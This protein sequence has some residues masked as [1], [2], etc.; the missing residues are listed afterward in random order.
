LVSEPVFD[1]HVGLWKCPYCS[2]MAASRT[3]VARHIQ[4]EHSSE[5]RSHPS[6]NQ[7]KSSNKP[8]LYN[9]KKPKNGKGHNSKEKRDNG[10]KK[11]KKSQKDWQFELYHNYIFELCHNKKAMVKLQNGQTFFGKLHARDAVSSCSSF[12]IIS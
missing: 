10:K 3:L 8:G 4:R 12:C 11:P 1:Q 5:V 2:F 7:Q 9:H 6:Q